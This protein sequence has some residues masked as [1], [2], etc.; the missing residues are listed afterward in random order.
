M[1]LVNRITKL[2]VLSDMCSSRSVSPYL[3]AV[4]RLSIEW[5]SKSRTTREL[6]KGSRRAC[7]V[8]ACQLRNRDLTVV[9]CSVS[10]IVRRTK[11]GIQSGCDDG[12]HDGR[13]GGQYD[14]PAARRS[15]LPQSVPLSRVLRTSLIKVCVH[16]INII[17]I[18]LI[19][20]IYVIPHTKYSFC[21]YELA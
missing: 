13:T 4:K 16:Y 5:S 11:R 6:W 20:F 21:F 19:S 17:I 12:L 7:P 14:A 10:T 3:F 9:M 15:Y 18:I 2:A 8:P 1:T